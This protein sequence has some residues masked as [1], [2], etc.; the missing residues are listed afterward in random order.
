MAVPKGTRIGGR[1]KGTPNKSTGALAERIRSWGSDPFKTLS[2]IERG[3]LP[4]G[5]CRGKGKTK[6]QPRRSEDHLDGTFRLEERTCQSCYGSGKERL[7]PAERGKAAAELAQYLEPKRKAIE[8]S[9][10]GGGPVLTKIEVVMVAAV[11]GK[12]VCV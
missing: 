3:E 8:V 9:G 11:D 6:Y 10:S 1:Q 12:R 2:D 4:C 5:V 7:S